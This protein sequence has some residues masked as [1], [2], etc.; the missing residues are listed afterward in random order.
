M[1]SSAL[2]RASEGDS[3]IFVGRKMGQSPVP[4]RSLI[5]ELR[6]TR[7]TE[8]RSRLRPTRTVLLRALELVTM[9]A[10]PVGA[11]SPS[12]VRS[13]ITTLAIA[14]PRRRWRQEAVSFRSTLT[15]PHLTMPELITPEFA[16]SRITPTKITRA[17]T[18]LL[19]LE[20]RATWAE[21]F[22]LQSLSAIWAIVRATVRLNALVIAIPRRQRR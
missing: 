11:R 18:A 22:G 6:T 13:K 1:D 19:A 2:E 14:I 8:T 21:A 16:P 4:R 5:S 7:A 17:A 10:K 9:R 3:P 20:F 12:V 15:T